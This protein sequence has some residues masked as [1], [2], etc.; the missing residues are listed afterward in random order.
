VTGVSPASVSHRVFVYVT[1]FRIFTDDPP[2][3]MI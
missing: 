3:A 2:D 1:P